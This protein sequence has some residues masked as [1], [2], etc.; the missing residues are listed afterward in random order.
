MTILLTGASGFL[1]SHIAEQ[2]SQQ[3][4]AVRALV[5]AQSDTRHLRELPNVE[6]VSAGLHDVEALTR[7]MQGVTGVIHAAGLVKARHVDEFHRV[8]AQGTG[9]LI[10]AAKKT[11]TLQRF[12]LVSSLSVAGPSADGLPVAITAAPNPVTHYGRS[13]LAAERIALAAKDQLPLTI[14]RPP[15]IYGPRDREVYAFFQAVKLGVLPYMGSTNR[16]VSAI[17]ASDCA[18]ACISALNKDTPSGNA[19]FVDDGRTETLGQL[20]GHIETAMSKRARIRFPIPRSVLHFAALGSEYYGKWTDRAVMLT[21][22]KC[23]ELYAPHWVCDSSAARRDLGWEPLVTFDRGARI[24]YEWY[25]SQG[26]L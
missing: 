11:P 2:L 3:G 23:N 17:F 15:L 5:R 21:R 1:G 25:K 20:V 10:E 8:N 6:L 9:A 12:V 22:D 14:V 7:A 16:G 18:S 24:T 26:W 19:Y 4:Q 13:K